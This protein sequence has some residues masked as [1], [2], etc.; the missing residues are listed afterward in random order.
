MP[1]ALLSALLIFVLRCID[2]SLGTLRLILTVQGRRSLAAVIGFVEVSVFI[3]AVASVVAGPL[4]P[5]RVLAYGGGFAAGTFLGMTIDRRIALGDVVVRAITRAFQP[6]VEALTAAGFGVTLVEAR[7]GRGSEVGVLF[8]VAHRRRVSDLL[9][10]M[11]EVDPNAIVTVQEV[12]QQLHGYFTP[13]RPGL[14]PLGPL[15]QDR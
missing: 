12:R 14:A 6:M 4:S 15:E 11:R 3:T 10:T 7:G 5:L 8:S 1:E 9:A 2:V 13:K